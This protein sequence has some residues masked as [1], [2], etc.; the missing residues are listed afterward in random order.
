VQ[1]AW[2]GRVEFDAKPKRV[3]RTNCSKNTRQWHFI[4]RVS[5]ATLGT[6][7]RNRDSYNCVSTH[8]SDSVWSVAQMK[9]HVCF[10]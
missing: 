4:S 1:V 3:W 5:E 7:N 8:I 10:I 6:T 9:H 2:L